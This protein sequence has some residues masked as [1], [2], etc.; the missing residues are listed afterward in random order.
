MKKIIYIFF[1]FFCSNLLAQVTVNAVVNKNSVAENE[2][3]VFEIISNTSCGISQPDFG[4][5]NVVSGPFQS[6]SSSYTSINGVATKNVEIKYSYKLSAPKKGKY[7]IDAVSLNC[8]GALY[9]TKAIN[10]QVSEGQQNTVGGNQ[11]INTDSEFFIRISASKNNVYVGENFLLTLKLYARNQPQSIDGVSIGSAKGIWKKDLDADKTNFV[12]QVE[13]INGVRYNVAT[14]KRELCYAQKNGTLVIE[15]YY[16]SALFSKGFFQQY[17]LEATSNKLEINAIPLPENQPKNFNGLVGDFTVS[18]KISRDKLKPGE[19]IDFNIT[20]KGEGNLSVFDQPVLKFPKDFDVY[21]P[22]IKDKTKASVSGISGEISFDYVVIPTFYGDYTFPSYSFSYFDIKAKKY[23]QLSTE[24]FKIHVEKPD[25]KHGEIITTKKEVE[26]EETD[27][28]YINEAKSSFFE[29]SDILFGKP[30]FVSLVSLP[31][32][33]LFILFFIKKKKNSLTKD[34]ILEINKKKAK[35]IALQKIS[36]LPE[37]ISNKEKLHK[38]NLILKEYIK[39]KLNWTEADSSLKNLVQK[40]VSSSVSTE[41]INEIKNLWNQLEMYQYAP[42]E[43]D[44]VDD[45]IK[46][47]EKTINQ[48]EEWL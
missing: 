36:Q 25:Q 31:F 11:N 35:K 2:V 24:E 32:L 42:V 7:T 18:S 33:A 45:I 10:I 6:S 20:I 38:T 9:K 5:L 16:L 29:E 47:V 26:I 23:K 17:R 15:P 30:I 14:L 22:E 13:V 46:L 1:V 37:G 34:E 43:A 19:A 12:T 39:V 4:G 27:I 44:K 3:F 48:L 28:R 41:N 40:L 8:N 21:D